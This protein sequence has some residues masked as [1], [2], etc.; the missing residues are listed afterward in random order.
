[1]VHSTFRI[2]PS[3]NEKHQP[4]SRLIRNSQE[5]MDIRNADSISI[6]EAY[7]LPVHLFMIAFYIL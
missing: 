7:F 5:A 2:I 3:E 1:M 6:D 4:E